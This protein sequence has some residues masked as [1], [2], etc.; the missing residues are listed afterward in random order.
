MICRATPPHPARPPSAGFSRNANCDGGD[1]ASMLIAADRVKSA[2]SADRRRV[3][4][5]A[6]VPEVVQAAGNLQLRAGADIAVKGLAVIAD[7]LDDPVEPV[8]GEAELFAEI[9]VG[10][11]SAFQ[12]RLVRF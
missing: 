5:S 6:L 11:E 1:R 8:L 4:D 9:A 3:L 2:G 10:A 12:I 7:G